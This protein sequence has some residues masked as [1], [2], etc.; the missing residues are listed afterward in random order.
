MTTPTP[1]A[2]LR[3]PIERLVRALAPTRIVLFGSYAKGIGTPGQ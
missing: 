1:P 2:F 3:T